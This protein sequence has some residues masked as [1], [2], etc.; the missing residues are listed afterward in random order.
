MGAN[1]MLNTF[2]TWKTNAKE[3][4]IGENLLSGFLQVIFF[5]AGQPLF[6]LM[7]FM[8]LQRAT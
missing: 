3:K 1:Y 8:I 6:L 2:F 4:T 7:I 5:G